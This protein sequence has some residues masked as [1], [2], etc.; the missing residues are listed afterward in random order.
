MWARHADEWR[1]PAQICSQWREASSVDARLL[2]TEATA[3]WWDTL[4]RLGITILV[5]R[6]YEHLA[7]SASLQEGRPRLGFFA[8]PHPSGLAVDRESNRVFLGSTRNPNQVYTLRPATSRLER[9]DMRLGPLRGAPL[10]PVGSAFFPGSL[11][12]HDLAWIGSSLYAN[13]VGHNAVVRLDLQGTFE[14]A[15]WPRCIEQDGAPVFAR[16]HIQLNSIAAGRTLRESYFTASS[17]AIERQ[18]PGH[19]NYQVN[20]RG[21]IFS[22][23]TREPVCSGLT[24]PHSARLDSG[25][26]WVANS[27]YG[28]VGFV[29]GGRLEVLARLPGWTRGLA[30][31]GDVAMVATSRVIPRYA[32]YAPG[33]DSAKSRCGVYA[34]CRNSGKVL[35]ALEWPNGNQVFA[36]DWIPS[37]ASSGFLF[38]ARSRGRSREIAFFYTYLTA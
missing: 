1:S 22:G 25:K 36:V 35:G 4:A 18:R 23:R 32:Q 34:I 30:I 16:N 27:G 11:Y 33:L 24:R 9:S 19:L 7:M 17:A 31:V 37:S 12:M 26:I 3:G 29:A 21:V 10:T 2:E 13:A 5:T 28:E 14:R 6:E 20:R 8:V 15:W 38:E